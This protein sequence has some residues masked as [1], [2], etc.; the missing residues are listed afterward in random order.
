MRILI[1][2]K[3]PETFLINYNRRKQLRY[4]QKIRGEEASV[5]GIRENRREIACFTGK[6][7]ICPN[8]KITN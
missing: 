8:I 1:H 6:D 4:R 2:I 3:V 5:K 7:N